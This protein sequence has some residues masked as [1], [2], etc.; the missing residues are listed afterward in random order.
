MGE[1]IVTPT[2]FL[3]AQIT[4]DKAVSTER[5]SFS[6]SGIEV[7]SGNI[8]DWVPLAV[9]DAQI[10]TLKPALYRIRA[11]LGA[12]YSEWVNTEIKEGEVTIRTFH[13]GKKTQ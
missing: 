8:I 10:I 11:V 12:L 1:V 5:I 7:H 6:R 13:F 9:G 3:K 4:L 2:G